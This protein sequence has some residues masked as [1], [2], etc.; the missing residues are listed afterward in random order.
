MMRLMQ[1]SMCGFGSSEE[2]NLQYW[3]GSARAAG[4]NKRSR[5]KPR[6]ERRIRG[7]ELITA[8]SI[9]YAEGGRVVD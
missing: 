9:S 7:A 5:D 3:T 2:P 8:E 6:K 4:E 1:K